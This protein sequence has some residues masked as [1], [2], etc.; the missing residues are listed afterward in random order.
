MAAQVIG[1]KVRIEVNNEGSYEGYVHNIDGATKK[2]T[3]AK[4]WCADF[5]LCIYCLII[6]S[7]YVHSRTQSVYIKIT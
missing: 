3:L 2:L 5:V 6:G 7:P 1:A 4:G